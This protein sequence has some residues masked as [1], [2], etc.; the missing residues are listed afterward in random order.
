V[1]AIILAGG[2]GTRLIPL[3]L[4]V[5]KPMVP[6]AEKPFLHYLLKMLHKEGVRRVIFSLGYLGDQIKDFFGEC[7]SGL[8]ISYVIE[9]EPLGTGGA[10]AVCMDKVNGGEVI[11]V[12]GDTF[13]QVDL[14]KMLASHK[15]H[16]ADMTIVLK[17]MRNFDRYGTVD[18]ENHHI[19]QF[20]EKRK[21]SKGLINT[22]TYCLNKNIFK[23]H[24]LPEKFSFETDF[25][26][27]KAHELNTNTYITEG[28]FIDIGIPEDYEKAQ[29]ELLDLH[30]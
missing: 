12:N 11:V 8:E 16:Q 29:K 17:E 5:P 6:V 27:S 1:E 14:I 30:L 19:K 23:Q 10:I 7:W 9:K 26:Q 20:N 22:G 15:K 13:C 25:L 18:I 3:T 24:N 21:I 4:T 28:Y 2:K